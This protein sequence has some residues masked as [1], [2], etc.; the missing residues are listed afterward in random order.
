M[1]DGV[2][3]PLLFTPIALR[4]VTARNRIVVSPMSQYCSVDG[5]PTDWHLV[6]LGK[7]AMGG[8]GIVFVEETAVEER[9]RKTYGCPGIYT[10]GQA[11]AWRRITDFLRSQGALSAIQLG[12]AGRKVATKA[13]WDGFAPLTDEDAR[14]GKPP[15]RGIAPSPIAFR[16]GALVPI[17]MDHDDIGHVI[18]AHVEACRRS[19][20]AGFD[21][22]EI[23]GAHGYIIQQFL[24]PITNR[25]H[26]GYG[27][28]LAGRMRFCLE[29]I[30][31]VRAAWPADRP[32]FFRASCVDG[33]G[34][35]WALDDTVALARELKA[36]GVDVIDCS[37]GGIEGPLTLAV[38]PRVPGYHVPFAERIRRD[39]GIPTMAVGLIT[40]A[41]Q[42]ETYLAE[43]RCD[44]VALAREMMW[45]PNWPIH[46][47]K[48][49]GGI[50]P[51]DLAPKSYAWWLRRREEVRKRYPTGK[52][53]AR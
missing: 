7:F 23:H 2:R 47:A 6:H 18:A 29:L 14:I 48:E 17:E 27:G 53:A 15:W 24:S 45:D 50:D 30:E 26:D 25:R 5:E 44:L 35:A 49:L 4:G 22:C 39:T 1:T 46:A 19:L 40:Q 31:A 38:V 42:A 43:G 10:D 20:D 33:K 13:P 11:R 52:E 28:D 12:H 16:P 9:S 41:A 34:G 21:I 51:L 8:A 37:S 36:R 3:V 32:L